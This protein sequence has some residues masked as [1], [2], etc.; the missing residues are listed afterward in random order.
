MGEEIKF[1]FKNP[2]G[3]EDFIIDGGRIEMSAEELE[4]CCRRAE[5]RRNAKR[6]YV[7]TTIYQCIGPCGE[8]WSFHDGMFTEINKKKGTGLCVRCRE[9]WIGEERILGDIFLGD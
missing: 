1:T 2:F 3:G 7:P 5:I 8:K 4:L 6:K 9:G